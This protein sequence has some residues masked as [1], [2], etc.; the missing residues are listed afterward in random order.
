MHEVFG[1]RLS[2]PAVTPAGTIMGT[3]A[4]YDSPFVGRLGATVIER[5][6]L[7][8]DP[9]A[10]RNVPILWQGMETEPIGTISMARDG[11]GGLTIAGRISNTQHGREALQLMR[12]GVVGDVGLEL[13]D[14]RARQ[15]TGQRRILGGRL[16][17]VDLLSLGYGPQRGARLGEINAAR[18]CLRWPCECEELGVAPGMRVVALDDVSEDRR[19]AA[20]A[21]LAAELGEDAGP[22]DTGF[23]ARRP[24]A[25]I[26]RVDVHVAAD[27]REAVVRS[28]HASLQRLGLDPARAPVRLAFYREQLHDGDALTWYPA[29]TLYDVTP[30]MLGFA[31][32]RDDGS[33]LIGINVDRVEDRHAAAR[34]TAHEVYHAVA[35]LRDGSGGTEAGALAFENWASDPRRNPRWWSA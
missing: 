28:L 2:S 9:I 19:A 30:G 1:G 31:R 3:A 23:A 34:T 25:W 27:V 14:V 24:R 15:E 13:I 18:R 8:D 10:G 6:F 32:L 20:D 26:A 21:A 16:V 11:W 4:V 33:A 17:A 29:G 12:D 5:G 7:G 22:P 35:F